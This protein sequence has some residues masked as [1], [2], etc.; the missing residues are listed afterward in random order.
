[1]AVFGLGHLVHT[2]P[3][4]IKMHFGG[5]EGLG[6]APGGRFFA[7]FLHFL[8]K[9]GTK[10]LRLTPLNK[11]MA[12]FGIGHLEHIPPQQKNA[13]RGVRGVG[14]APGGRFFAHFWRFL[15]KIGT[16]QPGLGV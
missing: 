9:M 1:M 2:P 14:G 13:F 11:L 12:F 10:H 16:V 6:G 3:P 8:L 7:H 4:N 15:L 5:S